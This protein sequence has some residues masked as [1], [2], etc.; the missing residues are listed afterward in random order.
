LYIPSIW[1]NY[2]CC[3]L[4]K[5]NVSL[6]NNIGDEWPGLSI[7]ISLGNWRII[8]GGIYISKEKWKNYALLIHEWNVTLIF[9]TMFLLNC[10]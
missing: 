10:L 7:V 6:A 2:D 8:N 4:A 5:N 3:A 1:K 9:F